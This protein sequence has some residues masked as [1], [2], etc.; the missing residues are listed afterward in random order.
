MAKTHVVFIK[1]APASPRQGGPP[2][3][4][5][6][7]IKDVAGGFFRNAL[8][9]QGIAVLATSDRIK[10]ARA[11]QRTREHAAETHR[12]RMEMWAKELEGMTLEFVKKANEQGG[13]FDA[14]DKREILAVLHQKGFTGIEEKYIDMERP[15]DKIG[16]YMINLNLGENFATPSVKIIIQKEE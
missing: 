6:G 4:R 8:M 2:H 14:V 12:E 7:D 10:Q 13:L 11:M 16:E 3:G 5:A 1:D 9:P 15:F